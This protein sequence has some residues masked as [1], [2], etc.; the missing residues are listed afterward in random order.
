MLCFT[1]TIVFYA[2]EFSY[3]EFPE[4]DNIYRYVHCVNLPEGMEKYAFTSA[5]TGPAIQEK[6]ANV[7]LF[8]RLLLQPMVLRTEGQDVGFNEDRFVF[9]D[10]TFERFFPFA[11]R[12]GKI[13]SL[14]KEPLS[15]V[16]S[17]RAAKK[18]FGDENPLGKM[19]IATDDTGFKVTGVY[20]ENISKTHL[21]SLDF[22]ASFTSARMG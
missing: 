4:A 9:A 3:D 17:P 12:A 13:G 15:V 5:M 11:L 8:C 1:V 7:Q 10:S 2:H 20:S 18:Y 16:I 14:L 6:F 19:L 22:I 21:G